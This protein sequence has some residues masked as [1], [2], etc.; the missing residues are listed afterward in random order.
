VLRDWNGEWVFCVLMM[1]T[2]A[3]KGEDWWLIMANYVVMN[4]GEGSCSKCKL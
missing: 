4:D 2:I 3:K 1:P